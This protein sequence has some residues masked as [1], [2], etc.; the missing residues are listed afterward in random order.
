M[1][2]VSHI[3]FQ[4]SLAGL[5]GLDITLLEIIPHRAKYHMIT[6]RETIA[7]L[8]FCGSVGVPAPPGQEKIEDDFLADDR[9]DMRQIF[10]VV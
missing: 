5:I 3:H 10:S 4:N 7:I 1:H 9:F 8:M 2:S 6:D